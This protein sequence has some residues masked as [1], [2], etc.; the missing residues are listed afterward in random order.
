MTVLVKLKV[1]SESTIDDAMKQT[2][3]P[4]LMTANE[5][6]AIE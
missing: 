2:N 5:R 1:M 6:Q 3:N 4:N